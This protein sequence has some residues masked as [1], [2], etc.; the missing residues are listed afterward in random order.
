MSTKVADFKYAPMH[1]TKVKS[2]SGQP[3]LSRAKKIHQEDDSVFTDVAFDSD[4]AGDDED[5]EDEELDLDVKMDEKELEE[6]Y[7]KILP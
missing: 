7:L 5:V 6:E 4:E 1:P 3:R 2:P